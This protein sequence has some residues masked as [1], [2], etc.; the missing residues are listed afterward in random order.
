MCNIY[1]YIYII[2]IYSRFLDRAFAGY[3]RLA[4][5][6]TFVSHGGVYLRPASNHR[7]SPSLRL[8]RWRKST[9]DF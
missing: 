5:T 3:P 9:G 2:Y 6:A 4:M 7:C 8:S 1:N